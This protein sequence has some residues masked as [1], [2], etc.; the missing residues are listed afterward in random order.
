MAMQTNPVGWSPLLQEVVA[1]A[2]PDLRSSAAKL[3]HRLGKSP[4]MTSGPEVRVWHVSAVLPAQVAGSSTIGFTIDQLRDL[5]RLH[6]RANG[7]FAN[8]RTSIR[9]TAER[10]GKLF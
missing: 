1:T 2:R 4:T 9:W 7:D 6:R 10:R 5:D 3:L 8:D